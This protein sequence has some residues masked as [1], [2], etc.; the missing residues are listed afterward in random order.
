[1]K[2]VWKKRI[3]L[4]VAPALLLVSGCDFSPADSAVEGRKAFESGD[5]AAAR[6]HLINAI[7]ENGED[8]S[9]K[10]LYAQSLLKLGDGYGA[11]VVLQKLTTHPEF[12]DV[13]AALLAQALFYKGQYED[14]LELTET[15]EG[16]QLARL[17]W[18]RGSAL[19]A[20]EREVEAN[21]LVREAREKDPEDAALAELDGNISILLGEFA[22]AQSIAQDLV[23]RYPKMSEA[24]LLAG[25]VARI[26]GNEKQAR[27]HFAAV[28]KAS[29]NHAR[30][31]SAMGDSFRQSGMLDDARSYYQKAMR[32]SPNDLTTL[33]SLGELELLDGRLDIAL[34]IT[35]ANE[36]ELKKVPIGLRLLGMVEEASG[37]HEM[38]R[39]Y[40]VRYRRDNK[41]DPLA[42]SSLAR[43]L[44]ALGE[45]DEARNLSATV[46]KYEGKAGTL[47]QEMG[48]I[49]PAD[50]T[51]IEA[52]SLAMNE[53]RWSDA[54][55]KFAQ[56]TARSG[57]A[58][59]AVFNN[60]AMVKLQ[61]GKRAE[62][63]PLARRAYALAPEDPFVQDTWGW[64]LFINGREPVQAA[65]LVNKAYEQRPD[66][67]EISWHFAQILARAGH[68]EEARN[69]MVSL[70]QVMPK[71]DHAK[72]D[73]LIARL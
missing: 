39:T 45:N 34:E 49:S 11:E 15:I 43:S 30:A 27:K 61:L 6:I 68:R 56:L 28:L 65:K 46:A 54:D 33:I 71:R 51:L 7:K 25:R 29:P 31:L 5:Y 66:S 20:L 23:S 64:T 19:M 35:R 9:L 12:G 41:D 52:A 32:V 63:L 47:Q 4:A 42:A 57:F 22:R 55:A 3:G 18:A 60:A 48:Q 73:G 38:A 14:V 70:K 37:N 13:A 58:N 1:M 2:S 69:V 50:R 44:S 67:F 17:A 8:A 16:P 10:L 21:R 24:Q 36:L 62:A 26:D 59:T 40:L 53:Q 72:I